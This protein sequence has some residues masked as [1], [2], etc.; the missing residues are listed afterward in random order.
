MSYMLTRHPAGFFLTW[1]CNCLPVCTLKTLVMSTTLIDAVRS[2]FSE[3]LVNKFASLLGESEVN[4]S[5]AVH[6]SIA[7]VLTDITHKSFFQ[8]EA[9]KLASQARQAAGSDF[10]GY[11]HELNTGTGGLIA[12]SALLNK[13]AEFESSIF[14]IRS[15]AVNGEIGRY[16][17]ISITSAAFIMGIASFAALDAIGRHMAHS[18]MDARN[19]AAW[20]TTQS[21]S[22]SQAIPVGLQVRPVLGIKHFPWERPVRPRKN[23]GLYIVIVL[24][25]LAA[26]AF[27][28]YHYHEKGELGYVVPMKL[29]WALSS[30][31]TRW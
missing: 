2:V 6:G 31:I 11:L 18:T 28:I 10:F 5:K 13:G 25:I 7:M 4:F 26:A 29:N 20:L 9:T 22:M 19:T 21:D 17:G 12:G 3:G 8:E 1:H 23:A 14:G 24:I 30:G 15:D 27:V 16:A